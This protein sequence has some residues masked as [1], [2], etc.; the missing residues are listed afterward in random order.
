MD[1]GLYLSA[2]LSEINE[3]LS[4]P[5]VRGDCEDLPGSYECHCPPGYTGK[6]CEIGRLEKQTRYKVSAHNYKNMPSYEGHCAIRSPRKSSKEHSNVK[7]DC[8][9]YHDKYI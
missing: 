5:C 2:L 3:C 7:E 4:S 8:I 1:R 6:N 9:Q